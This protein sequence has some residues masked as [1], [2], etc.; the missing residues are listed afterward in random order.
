MDMYQQFSDAMKRH[1]DSGNSP[2]CDTKRD[3]PNN[4]NRL[5]YWFPLIPSGIRV[6]RTLIMKYT[7]LGSR[8]SR[9]ANDLINLLD[10][11][12]PPG[13][14]NF[15]AMVMDAGNKV[16]WPFFLRTDY[17][18]GKHCWKDTCYVQDPTCNIS[19]HIVSLVETSALADILGFPTDVWV[20]R[21]MIPTTPAFTAFWGDMPIVKERRYFVQ[22]DKVVCHHP[23]WPPDAFE[24][25]RISRDNWRHRLDIMN[26]ETHDEIELLSGLSSKVGEA[27]GGAW[28]I[29]WLWSEQKAQ[30]FLTD[31]A[32][33]KSSYH[34]SGCPEGD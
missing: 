2:R 14:N 25:C 18:S 34:W 17:M 15:C 4:R 22:D 31:M 11:K 3:N 12:I 7:N 10:G 26:T 27:I 6:P 30:W 28:S 16:G 29:D 33:A 13:F 24:N 32:E 21:E 1:A 23:Y 20:V 19:K 5:S 9:D 8:E